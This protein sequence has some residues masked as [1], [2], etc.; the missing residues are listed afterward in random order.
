V[1]HRRTAVKVLH[2]EYAES[3]E[4]VDRF[5][6]EALAASAIGHPNI[7]EVHDVGQ[8][9]DGTTYIVMELLKGQ[10]MGSLLA[11]EGRL[12]PAR[13]VAI[14]LQILSALHEAHRKGI[15]H[16]DMKPDNVFLSVDPRLREEVKLLDFGVAKIQG[17]LE[18]QESM[19][20]TRT[21]MTLGTP[22]YIAPEQARGRKDIDARV[23]LWALGVMMYEMLSGRLPFEGE[24]YNE[25]IS[26]VL[27]EHHEPL[28]DA[29]PDVP[30]RL[31]EI[32]ERS[33]VKERDQRYQSATEMIGDL[34]PLHDE[35]SA[36]R[37][38]SSVDLALRRTSDPPPAPMAETMP[39]EAYDFDARD[40]RES[41]TKTWLLNSDIPAAASR[42]GRI[43][44]GRVAVAGAAVVLAG[45]AIL[46]LVLQ[47]PT[48][49]DEPSDDGLV[50][51]AAEPEV[52]A[53]AAADPVPEAVA[54]QP[55]TE[56]ISLPETIEV[57][58]GELPRGA[59]VWIDG[60]RAQ[61]PLVLPGSDQPVI[62]KVT[63]PGYNSYEKALV[64]DRDY[65]VHVSM[66]RKTTG[67]KPGPKPRN[68]ASKRE[69]LGQVW[70]DNPFSE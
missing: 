30:V 54:V 1:L 14:V 58:L 4:A 52:A 64:P 23:D 41:S 27:L 39:L 5:L 13:V 29:A 45:A 20:L 67:G 7:I 49:V 68:K 43:R 17:C 56:P 61:V 26:N 31:A 33:L 8:E 25:I 48:A 3:T 16:R 57:H 21:G 69:G 53:P 6:R 28:L 66:A 24:G 60:E 36:Y 42:T 46:A 63:A 40:M 19:S 11:M 32:V 50:K 47:P 65:E 18:G 12:D 10:D 9:I 44:W 15:V 34:L 38:T 70:A 2:P 51:P 59:R 55:E 35:H 37:L 62:L 22:Y